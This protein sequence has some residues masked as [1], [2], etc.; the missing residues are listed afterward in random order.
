MESEVGAS[1]DDQAADLQ[2]GGGSLGSLAVG[3]G[4]KRLNW[5]GSIRWYL[6]SIWLYLGFYLVALV[7]YLVVFRIYLVALS[8]LSIHG[9]YRIYFVVLRIYLRV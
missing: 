9:T 5:P 2:R 8:D 7:I 3:E 4:S 6:G 1:E